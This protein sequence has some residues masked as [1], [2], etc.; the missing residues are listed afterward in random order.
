MTTIVGPGADILR[1]LGGEAR[2]DAI[3]AVFSQDDSEHISLMF[4]HAPPSGARSV[5]ITAEPGGT[6]SMKCY[7]PMRVGFEAPTIGRATGIVAESL[8]SVLGKLT[9]VESLHHHHF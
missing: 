5:I 4:R 2:L 8:A 9:G 7:G 1:H 3:G 6:F